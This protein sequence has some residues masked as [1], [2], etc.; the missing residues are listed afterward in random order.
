VY[1]VRETEELILMAK[2]NLGKIAFFI[3]IAL[4]FIAGA[5]ITFDTD[6]IVLSEINSALGNDN[7]SLSP[8]QYESLLAQID[9]GQNPIDEDEELV[10]D[11]GVIAPAPSPQKG[12]GGPGNK[13]KG[14]I[15][16]LKPTPSPTPRPLSDP[17]YLV[18]PSLK[19][20][21][22]VKSTPAGKIIASARTVSWYNDSGKPGEKGTMAL[23]AGHGSWRGSY[24]SFRKIGKL[25]VGDEVIIKYKDKRDKEATFKVVSV[26]EYP[27]D[28][29][30][31][32][33]A[34]PEKAMIA[35]VTCSGKWNSKISTHT[36]R[37]I[38]ICELRT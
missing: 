4:A 32:F 13:N 26:G 11:G 28:N 12:T 30:P 36:N 25:K 34:D 2:K 7:S 10:D 9:N 21:A 37:T 27:Y 35:L 20:I 29:V 16:N 18:I 23:F 5:I 15:S 22:P 1:K 17:K 33:A 14:N 6:S 19:V 24:G 31:V 8:S 3:I 38:V